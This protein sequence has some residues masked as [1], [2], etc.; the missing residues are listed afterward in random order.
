MAETKE[1]RARALIK[2]WAKRYLDDPGHVRSEKLR[3]ELWQVRNPGVNGAPEL[4]EWPQDLIDKDDE[5]MAAV[6]HYYLCRAWVGNGVYPAWQLKAMKGIYNLG[7]KAGVTPRSNPDKAV[8][9]VSD[10]QVS[11]QDEGIR[12]GELDLVVA[13]KEAPAVAM[14]VKYW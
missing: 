8:T 7:K 12:M 3:K 9:P 6:E 2:A 10:M 1:A 11:L 14:P 5:V 13:G 4:S